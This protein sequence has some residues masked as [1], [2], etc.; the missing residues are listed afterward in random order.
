M[1]FNHSL[2][3]TVI[4]VAISSVALAAAAPAPREASVALGY[5]GTTGNTD[6]STFNTEFLLTLRSA[7]WTHNGKLQALGS[8][9]NSVTKA[10]RYLLED[11]SDFNLDESQYLFG[12]GT[13]LDD[14]FSGYSY[15]A[16]V[17][18]G[19]GRYLIRND[20][21]NLEAFGGVGYRQNAIANLTSEG[22]AIVTLG[23]KLQW[24]ISDGTTLVQSLTSDIGSDL[25]MTIFE[26]GL[27][28][29]IIDRIATK[30]AFQARNISE[31]PVGKK[32]TD[33]QT[34]VSLSY[35]F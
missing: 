34:S 10:E 11:K 7:Q 30:I 16:T 15:Q 3:L 17:S 1:K 18:A 4:G 25:T 2:L 35:S 27:V 5:V 23:E 6:T 22:N 20:N 24:S 21:F 9:E 14:R 19:Y 12:K 32:T 13:Y 28:S 26:V 33:T 29:Q 31:V 8:Q